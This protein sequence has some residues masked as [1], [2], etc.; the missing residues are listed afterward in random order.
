MNIKNKLSGEKF[1]SDVYNNRLQIYKENRGKSCVYCWYNFFDHKFYVGST[2]NLNT[3]LSC[4]LSNKYLNKSIL[5][6][7]SLIY[8]S[9]LK[10]GY[11]N[12]DLIIL[13]YCDIDE[14]TKWEQYYIDELKPEYNILKV[15]GSRFRVKS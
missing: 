10:Y 7:K 15:A 3:R 1:Y 6:S 4:Y 9:M 14:L 5:R 8:K 13:K 2:I 11:S 12:F